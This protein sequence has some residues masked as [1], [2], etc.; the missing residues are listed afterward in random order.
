[1]EEFIYFVHQDEINKKTNE[2][3]ERREEVNIIV[4]QDGIN[5]ITE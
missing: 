5:K 2:V 4:H 1:M 3:G